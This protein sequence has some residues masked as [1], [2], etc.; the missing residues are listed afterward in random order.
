MAG[1]KAWI[2]PI[3]AAGLPVCLIVGLVAALIQISANR[4]LAQ[5]FDYLALLILRRILNTSIALFA[6]AS[7]LALGAIRLIA[8]IS[9]ARRGVPG[10]VAGPARSALDSRGASARDALGIGG[11]P[12]R[13]ALE[14]GGA[15]TR[16]APNPDADQSGGASPE[17]R[18]ARALQAALALLALTAVMAAFLI[19][20]FFPS[21]NAAVRTS[22]AVDAAQELLGPVGD[23][24]G[25]RAGKVLIM[26][27]GAVSA[28]ALLV[29][30]T[31]HLFG[32]DCGAAALDRL[33]A[34]GRVRRS[35]EIA[36]VALLLLVAGVN[37]AV[38]LLGRAYSASA[39][40]I[41]LISLETVR[42]DHLEAWGYE[43][44][45]APALAALARRGVLN[46]NAIA[47]APWTLPSMATV[48]TGLYLSEHGA[49]GHKSKLG[50]RFATLAEHLAESGY[51]T[52][53]VVSWPFVTRTHG[54]DQGFTLF[55]QD[56]IAEDGSEVLA[57]EVTRRALRMIDSAGDAP[58]F[59]WLHYVEPHGAYVDHE[60][61]DHASGYRGFL[62][63]V[64]DLEALYEVKERL[65]EEDLRYVRDLYDEE[66]TVL[67]RSLGDLL[68]S[69][70][71]RGL[72]GETVIVALGDHGEEFLERGQF[73]HA[74]HLYQELIHVPLVIVDPR[75]PA[76]AGLRVEEHVELRSV[77]RTILALAAGE[78]HPP[79]SRTGLHEWIQ[80]LD[81]ARGTA[82]SGPVF[83]EYVDQWG[84]YAERKAVLEGRYKMIRDAGG[85]PAELYDLA[86]DP[87][88]RRDLL[89][90]A[91]SPAGDAMPDDAAPPDAAAGG[92]ASHDAVAS[93]GEAAEAGARLA[94]A[95]DALWNLPARDGDEAILTEEEIERLRT[96]GYIR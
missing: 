13:R 35:L 57:P 43:R 18:P 80:L 79:E 71:K 9:S 25:T 3:A 64:V 50:A 74:R 69:L 5:G 68:D 19:V 51:R 76:L 85:S 83:S 7:I 70:E 84:I 54:F 24:L 8:L 38:P 88:E 67:D 20:E 11:G 63:P 82:A 29:M 95:L 23:F 34:G 44:P 40:N 91:N 87:G 48:H 52:M 21:L 12:A 60:E 33:L 62:P 93:E 39:P 31:M 16:P 58:F 65:Q 55:D 53:A 89:A 73:G 2:R 56:V 81:L 72:D 26:M 17:S 75:D 6:A 78:D 30:V 94:R 14:A 36:A 10:A 41:I 45:T 61:V 49:A 28:G 96:L 37:A 32:R 92:A 86:S 42:A 46:A 4:Y 15:P 22:A 77:A 90:Q 66:I 1:V 59:M 47:Q 27:A